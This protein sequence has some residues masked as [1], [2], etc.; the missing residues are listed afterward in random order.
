MS[1]PADPAVVQYC[2]QRARRA[3]PRCG[4][5]VVVGID[6]PAGSGKTTLGRA[7]SADLAA[8]LVQMD[9]LLEGWDGLFEISPTLARAVLEPLAR[10]RA[11]TYRRYDWVHGTPAEWHEVG[12]VPVLVVEGVGSTL[13]PAAG[14]VAV[15][16]WVEA[17]LAVRLARGLARD[18]VPGAAYR[19][20]WRRWQG[21]EDALFAAQHTRA[22]A[23]VRVDTWIDS[24][25]NQ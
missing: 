8:P 13:E 1:R 6:G 14:Y 16:V 10:G 15:R 3:T 17:P 23:D 19:D 20:R 9:D 2:A 24:A 25:D 4:S 11:G 18:G 7:L 22:Y 5:V 21:Q 12:L